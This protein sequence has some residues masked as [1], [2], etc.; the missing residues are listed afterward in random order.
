MN[1]AYVWGF[2]AYVAWMDFVTGAWMQP[3]RAR[4]VEVK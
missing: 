1:V 3:R 2:A 4:K